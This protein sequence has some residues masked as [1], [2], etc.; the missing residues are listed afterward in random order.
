MAISVN[1]LVIDQIRTG[2]LATWLKLEL[3]WSSFDQAMETSNF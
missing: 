2:N 1:G 3:V